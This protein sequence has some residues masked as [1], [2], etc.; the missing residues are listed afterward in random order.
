MTPLFLGLEGPALTGAER[1]FFASLD[2][3]GYILFKRNVV[4]PEQVRALT[5]DL[6]SLSGRDDLP[7]LIDQ[8]GGRVA[9]LGPPHWPKFPPG[10]AFERLYDVAPVSAIE[11]IRHNCRALGL[12]L[13]ELGITVDCLPVL[14]VPVPGAHDI[15]GDRALGH[16][17]MRV[18][19]LGKAS[20]EGLAQ[21]GVVGVIKHIPGHGRAASDSHVELPVVTAGLDEL[22]IDLEPFEKLNNAPMAMTAH[23]V[24][25]ALDPDRCAS[26]SPIVI[27]DIIRGRIGFDGLLMSDDL[28]M[29]ALQGS[30]ADRARGVIDAGCDIVLHCSG[31]MAEMEEVAGAVTAIAPKAKDRL[32]RAMAS[33]ASGMNAGFA[34]AIEKRDALLALADQPHLA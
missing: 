27:R 23:V 13:A 3:A 6:R 16:E 2:P 11:A 30:F 24:Y 21:G 20:I 34:E 26:L 22:A 7:I 12:M 28:G 4:D 1:S 5:D 32:A 25:T 18:A 29:H 8:E 15:I 17:P 10:R 19:A 9:R 14:D 33:A 31:N